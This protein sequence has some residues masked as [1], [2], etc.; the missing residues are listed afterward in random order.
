MTTMN[1]LFLLALLMFLFACGQGGTADTKTISGADS[2]NTVEAV[3]RIRSME[4]SLFAKPV[5]DRKGAMALRDV[6]LAFAKTNPLDTMTPEYLFRCAGVYR[7]LGEPQ[8]TMK[9]YDRI[10]SNY[11]GWRRLADTYYLRAFTLDN[12][13]DQKGE[14][15]AAYEEVINR[16][17]GHPF[18]K[19]AEHMIQNLQYTDE[20]LIEKFKKM[21]A[22]AEAAKG[23]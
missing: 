6:Y 20:Q 9:V 14:A 19:D 13:L 10:I 7:T 5:Y 15:K 21:N 17:P 3:K 22:E 16:Y 18:A 2:T 12:D 11:P 1:K 8:E 4:D 23:K